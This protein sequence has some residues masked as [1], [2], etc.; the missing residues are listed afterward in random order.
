[1][2]TTTTT[3]RL[4]KMPTLTNGGGL[5]LFMIMFVGLTLSYLTKEN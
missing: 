2:S 3:E 4:N 5:V 1:M